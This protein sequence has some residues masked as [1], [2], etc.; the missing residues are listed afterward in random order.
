MI[1]NITPGAEL[2]DL[3]VAWQN[4]DGTPVDFVASPHTFRLVIDFETPVE[5]TTGITGGVG[6]VTIAFAVGETDSY[7]PGHVSAQLWA[8]RTADNKDREPVRLLVHVQA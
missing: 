6:L 4:N 8:K 7:P 1:L 3:A 2:P 5:K